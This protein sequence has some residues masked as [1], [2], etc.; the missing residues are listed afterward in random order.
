MKVCGC[1][2]CFG[3][4]GGIFEIGVTLLGQQCSGHACEHVTSPCS[5]QGGWRPARH[6]HATH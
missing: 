3:N 1:G 4:G 2:S 6:E 5:G